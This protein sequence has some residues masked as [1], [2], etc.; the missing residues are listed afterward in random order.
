MRDR[1]DNINSAV[2]GTCEWLLRHET[3]RT[4]TASD[5]GLL[6]IKGKPGSG[7]ST[8]LK[9]GV[10]NHRGRDSDLV[11]A[12]FFHDRGHKLQRSPLGLF[13]CLLHQILG[14]TPHALPD[15]IYTFENRCKELGRPGEDWQ[16]HEE[17]LGRLF[18]STLL[19]VL[20]TQSVWLYVD[21]LDECRKDDAV[22]LVDMLKSLLKSLPHRSTSLRQFRICFS[23]RYYPILDL[24]AMFEICLEYENREDISTFVDVRLSA[25]RARNSATIPALIKECASGVFLWA[26]LVVTQVLELER[27]GAGIKQMEETVRSKSSG[28]DILYRRLIRNMEPASLKLIQWICFATRPLSIEELGW[29][30]VLEVHCSHRSLEAFQSAE[31]IPNNDRMK[32]QVQTLSRG[33]AEVTGTQDV[34][35]IHLSVKDF[36]VEKGLS[37][38]SGGMTST[39]ATIE[40]HLRL[41][42]ICLRYL[43]M[44]EIGSASSSSSSSSSFSSS[45][46]SSSYRSFTRYSHTD[47]P[48]LR[49]ATFSWV[50]HAKQGDTTSVPQGDLLM[51]FASPT[52]SIMESWVRVYEDLDNWSADCPPKGTG[53]VHVMSRYGIFGLLTGILQTAHRTTLDIDAR[54]DFGR[55]PLSWAAEKGHEAVVKLLLDTGKAEINSKDI[56]INASDEDGRTP[57]SWAAEKGHEAIVKLLLDTRKVDV[58]AS[59]K[60]GRTPLSWAAQKG[61]EAIVKLLLDTQGYIQS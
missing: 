28:L 12:F 24:D 51:L 19:N 17:E 27:D 4:W 7:K 47:Y 8:L 9:Y 56:D 54:D 53:V 36:F 30:M 49:Y 26:R 13:R 37:A 40:A 10:D 33:L 60:D 44:Q 35:F 58:D 21:A 5:R 14:R 1:S 48:F 6:W 22:K 25:F 20:K 23:C 15:L 50:A 2:A 11:L 59:D 31:D 16:W 57:L 41:S 32:R 38:L 61:H 39:K 3:Y 29:A 52:N 34:Q 18:K 45:S 42:G 46:P 55:T 43:S